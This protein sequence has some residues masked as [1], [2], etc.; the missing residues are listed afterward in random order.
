MSTN[1]SEHTVSAGGPPSPADGNPLAGAHHYVTMKLTSRNFLFW[2]MQLVP[3]LRGQELLGYVDGSFPCPAAT[4]AA[5][6][7]GDSTSATPASVVPNP[8]HHA[9]VKQDQSI[10]SLLISS[11]SDEVLRQGNSTTA[12]YLGH[13]GV[14]AEVL[15]QAGRPL[16]LMEQNLYVI[17]GLRPELKTLAA[18]FTNGN[19]V[20]L[21]HLSDYLAANEF[22]EGRNQDR[23]HGSQEK[24]GE[25]SFLN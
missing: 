16:S 21:D 1:S 20:T 23:S 5:A 8:A 18:A 25:E 15:V 17:R 6:S 4:I 12:E 14:L 22:M 2:R 13:A 10:L 7:S 9:W 3:F 24:G 19:A 11:M